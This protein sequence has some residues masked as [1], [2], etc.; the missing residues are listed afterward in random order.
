M[1][2]WFCGCAG[3]GG[4]HGIAFDVFDNG[5]PYEIDFFIGK[6]AF[7]HDLR[8]PQLVAAVNDG[9]RRSVFGQKNGLFHG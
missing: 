1:F 4:N 7:L 5:I 6:G 8:S 3:R 2:R 9:D